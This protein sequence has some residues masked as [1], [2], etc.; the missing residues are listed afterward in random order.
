MN[1]ESKI[2][3]EL[4]FTCDD[5]SRHWLLG[6]RFIH[7]EVGEVQTGGVAEWEIRLPFFRRERTC[8]HT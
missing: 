7:H 8:S 6:R 4:E 1:Y 2:V 3:R 5:P